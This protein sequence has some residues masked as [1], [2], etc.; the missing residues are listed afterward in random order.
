MDYTKGGRG[1]QAPYTSTHVRI[2]EPI[3]DLV[4][5]LAG[6][7]RN[8]LTVPTL[9]NLAPLDAK[10][11]EK[12]NSPLPS[13]PSDLETIQSQAQTIRAYLS[14]INYLKHKLS[15]TDSQVT[16]SSA[17][18]GARKVV[19]QKKSARRSLIKLL[20]YIYRVDVTDELFG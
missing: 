20:T 9:A 16:L 6:Y 17:L 1:R 14:E 18:E 11:V 19:D 12:C 5:V 2:P 13:E 3:K 7:Y 10:N 15:Q 8:T 4:L